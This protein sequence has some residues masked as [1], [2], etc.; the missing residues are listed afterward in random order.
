[1]NAEEHA[2]QNRSRQVVIK[3]LG[4][5]HPEGSFTHY[6]PL[7][8]VMVSAARSA[9]REIFD[10]LGGRDLLKS[11]GEVYIKPNAVDAR[12]YTHTRPEVVRAV[13]EYWFEA[14]AR[15]IYLFE[16]STQANYTRLV[17]AA[18]GYAR[19]CK[20]TGARPVYLDEDATETFVFHG[21][22]SVAD[23]DPEGYDRTTFQMPRLVA[24]KL[25]RC[26]DENLYVN[27]PKLKT[28][29]M[30][31]VTL[32]IKN[33]WGLPA[34]GCRRFDHNFNLHHKLVDLLEYVRPDVTL[35]EGVEGTIHGHYP[36]TSLAD[37]CVKPFRVLLGSR[38]VVAADLV[39]ARIFGFGVADVPQLKLALERGYGDGI[40][41][42][43]DVILSGDLQSLDGIDLVGDMPAEG[44]YPF[45]LIDDFP[46]DVRLVRGV[47]RACREGCVNNALTGI[48]ILHADHG[49]RG[50]FTFVFGKAHDPQTIDAIEG[51]VLVVGPC[52]VG[53]V[54]ERLIARLGRRNVYLS[55]YCND[56]CAVTEALF[57]LMKVNPTRMTYLSPARAVYPYLVARLKGSSSRVPS[58]FSHLVKRG[59]HSAR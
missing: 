58:L 37:R 53:E 4:A 17:F 40:R 49:G 23:G 51:R 3:R 52:A 21:K 15:N 14:G 36:P 6:R 10:A 30:G 25:I 50:G 2:E 24:E 29:S 33:Q 57:H 38:N 39:G 32:G 31:V 44:K 8:T 47:R 12:P 7:S 42:P 20:Q 48:Q 18:N 41:G 54:A 55:D 56:L 11:S 43:E 16:N 19:I 13:I 59:G 26:R 22:K 1:M 35:I 45:D 34:H 28:H 5:P 46:A 9:V 27:L